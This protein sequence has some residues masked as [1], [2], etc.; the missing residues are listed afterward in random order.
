MSKKIIQAGKYASIPQLLIKK[1]HSMPSLRELVFKELKEGGSLRAYYDRKK[2]QTAERYRAVARATQHF[3]QNN[4]VDGRVLAHVPMFDFLMWHRKDKDFWK[5]NDN[6]KS[7]K[8]DT[9]D[10]KVY[11]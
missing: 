2:A 4:K 1:H 10:A 5:D 8:R 3:K 6:L 9:E 11:L 7:L